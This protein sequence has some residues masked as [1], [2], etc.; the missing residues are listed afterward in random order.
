MSFPHYPKCKHSGTQWLGEMPAHW[1]V[2]VLKR[3]IDS[4]RPLTYGIVQAGPHVEDGVPY[5]RPADME[6]EAGVT[7]SENLLRTSED[8][9]HAYSRSTIRTGD[10]VCSIGPS[11]GKVMVAPAMLDG[12]NLTQGTARIAVAPPHSARFVFW[13]LRSA[14]S[15][16]QWESAVGGATFRALN[17]GPLASTIVPVPPPDE[18]ERIARFLDTESAKIDARVAEQRRLID[19]LKEKRE[20]V[21]AHAVTQGLNP[22]APKRHTGID[23]L[24]AVPAHWDLLGASRIGALFGSE[25]V[26]EHHVSAEG[27][28]P[29]IKVGSLSPSKMKLESWDWFLDAKFASDYRTRSHFVV[30]PKRGAAIFTNKVNVVER[31]SVIDPNL[32][33]WQIGERAN[34]KFVAYLLKARRLEGLADVSTI[35]QLNN[36]HIA[37]ERF[38]IPPIAEQR[39]IVEFLDGRIDELDALTAKSEKIIELLHE[40]RA[41]LISAAVTGKIDVRDLADAN[42]EAA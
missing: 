19:L 41:A 6:E 1:D 39:A 32:M 4:T 21:I 24:G 27:G 30:F 35:P 3:L 16:A 15:F 37:P 40:R 12:A 7:S 29:F 5:I 13:V 42:T 14:P 26:P 33:G 34:L 36:K 17:L 9:A 23:W 28:I 10:L 22:K 38:P 18:Q 25:A 20:A 2:T 8:I 11:F 31:S